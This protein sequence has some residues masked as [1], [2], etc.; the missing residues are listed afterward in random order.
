MWAG[1]VTGKNLHASNE[2]KKHE[3]IYN[4]NPG[5]AGYNRVGARRLG[6]KNRCARWKPRRHFCSGPPL[7]EWFREHL[8]PAVTRSRCSIRGRRPVMEPGWTAPRSIRTTPENGTV[9]S[10]SRLFFDLGG[11][12]GSRIGDRFLAA[13]N[14]SYRSGRLAGLEVLVLRELEKEFCQL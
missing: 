5:R 13:C 10:S 11:Q 2:R 1:V 12:L 14:L 4:R 7:R 8:V 3:N 9:L 6:R